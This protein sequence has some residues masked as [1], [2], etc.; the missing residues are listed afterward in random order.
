MSLK[1]ISN[2]RI[3]ICNFVFNGVDLGYTLEGVTIE[4]VRNFVDLVVDKYGEAPV[5]KAVLGHKAT[6]TAKFAEPVAELLNRINPEGQNMTGTAGT[7]NAFGTDGGTLL[8]QFAAQLTLHPVKNAA[9]DYSE[10]IVYYKAVNTENIKLNY[11]VK[12][13]RACE[14]KFEALIDESYGSGRRLGHIGLTDIS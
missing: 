12:N 2:V 11:E 14:V 9:T 5:D 3:G 4:I 13:Q 8:R 1:Q 10:D 6:I 7:R